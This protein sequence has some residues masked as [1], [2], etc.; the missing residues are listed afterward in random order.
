MFSNSSLIQW[1][2]KKDL[3]SSCSISLPL[4]YLSI[5]FLQ[6]VFILFQI[7]YFLQII[8]WSLRTLLTLWH[9]LMTDWNFPNSQSWVSLPHP[10]NLLIHSSTQS[11]YWMGKWGSDAQDWELE[12]FPRR[13]SLMPQLEKALAPHSSTLAWK[14]PWMEE[15]GRL[16]TMGS[17]RVGHDW[18]DLAAAAMPQQVKTLPA[19][20]RD[21]GELGSIPGWGQSPGGGKWQPTLVFLPGKIPWTEEPGRL[22]TL[23]LQR[24]KHDWEI[25]TF[26]FTSSQ[27][28]CLLGLQDKVLQTELFKQTRFI[29]S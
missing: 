13:A 5:S 15:P 1:D 28:N 29:F 20:Q 9:N 6:V 4:N 25:N 17:H 27:Y 21:P 18:S 12:K 23:G 7:H 11:I 26:T 8:N 3:S 14:I 2:R 19:I 10:L 22:Q 16:Q 24:V